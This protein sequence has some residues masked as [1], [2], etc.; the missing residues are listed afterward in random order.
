MIPEITFEEQA[1]L[2]AVKHMPS[3]S[4]ILPFEPKMSAIS[5]LE[6]RLQAAVDKAEKELM[7]NYP[8][9]KYRPVTDKL[10]ALAKKLDFTTYKQ[11]VALFVSPLV[12]KIF[13]LD[14]PVE[15][16]IIVDESFEIRDL[17]Y[18]KR[19]IHKYLILVLSNNR[20]QVFLG[21]TTHF[22]RIALNK[23]E[24][25]E[26]YMNDLPERVANFSDTRDR[27]ETMM[28]KFFHYTDMGL[29]I[30]LNAY[31]LPLFIMGTHRTVGHFRK[32]T[33]NATRIT[34]CI[35][36]NY[37]EASEQDIRK[38]I[39]PYVADWKKIRQQ[40]VLQ[41]LDTAMS[42]QKL[43][44]G[45]RDVLKEANDKKGRLLVVEKNYMAPVEQ[46]NQGETAGK[47]VVDDIIETVLANGGDVEFADE[48][49]LKGYHRIAL[50]KYY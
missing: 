29:G 43:V 48:G 3:V 26:A 10:R 50:I 27:K 49:V 47:D 15:E 20:S 24:H 6:Q 32:I 14:I 8:A 5:D 39:A 28:G 25:L 45:I 37:D 35:H 33:H 41:R 31:A 12:Q 4:I 16:K 40:D 46:G 30:I 17:V 36:G 2:D 11:S 42:A 22:A 34:G 38:A 23:P 7:R 13:Y 21:N 44:T 9:E 19:D 18:S 1:I